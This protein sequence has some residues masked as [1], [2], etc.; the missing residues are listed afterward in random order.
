MKKIKTVLT[1]IVMLLSISSFAKG[2]EPEK[3]TPVVKAAFESDFSK[4]TLVK[5]EKTDEFYFA[6]FLLNNVKT[7]A[8]YTETGELLGTSRKILAE[9]MPLSVSIAL[10]DNYDGYEVDKSVVELT[11]A[12]VT[13]YYVTVSNKT[14]T[15]KLKCYSSG[16]LE[17]ESKIKR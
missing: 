4:A 12:G 8:A 7:D 16:E 14:Q 17:V 2:P 10:A 13:R 9:Q 1:A 11:F 15:V 3:V 6:S 5:W